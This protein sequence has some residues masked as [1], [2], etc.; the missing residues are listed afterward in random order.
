M[1][2]PWEQKVSEVA[3]MEPSG[4]HGMCGRMVD[5]RGGSMGMAMKNMDIGGIQI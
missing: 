5:W 3:G 4:E 2:R 1:G